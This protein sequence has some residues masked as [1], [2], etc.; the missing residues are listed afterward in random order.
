[1]ILK[2]WIDKPRYVTGGI[3]HSSS[4][5][6]G[7]LD[8]I[9][10]M[11]ASKSQNEEELVEVSRNETHRKLRAAEE[12]KKEMQ[13]FNFRRRWS[14]TKKVHTELIIGDDF[15]RKAEA[16]IENDEVS[17]QKEPGWQAVRRRR[18]RRTKADKKDRTLVKLPQR[19]VF[20]L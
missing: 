5:V 12:E 4:W 16:K 9:M 10:N 19:T 17:G 6:W 1:M 20:P 2:R 7:L 11:A 15:Q 3:G 14:K 13:C 18:R 8:T